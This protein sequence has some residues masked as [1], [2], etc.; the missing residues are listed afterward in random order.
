[1]RRIGLAVVVAL[2]LMLAPLAAGAQSAGKVYRIGVF[3]PATPPATSHFDEAFT[4]GLREHGYVEGQN[5]I[6]E[7]RYG[8]GR[9]ERMVEI[10]TELARMK[11]DVIVTSTDP[12][13]SAIKRQTRSIPIVMVGAS[14]PVGTGFIASLARPGGNITGTSRMSTELS[15][16]RLELLREAVPHISRVAVMWNPDVRGALLD[17]K[18]L[19]EPARSLR[20]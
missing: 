18:E 14:D 15:R 8:E 6:L 4:Q 12:A 5:V 20:L 9:V 19:E 11:V 17:F 16:K 2:S 13:I 3:F 7:R 1:M 10:A